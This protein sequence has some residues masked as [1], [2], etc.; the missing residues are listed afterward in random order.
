MSCRCPMIGGYDALSAGISPLLFEEEPIEGSGEQQ[1]VK[2]SRKLV[3]GWT[4]R[5]IGIVMDDFLHGRK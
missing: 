5:S 4:R 3:H 1:A 2:G